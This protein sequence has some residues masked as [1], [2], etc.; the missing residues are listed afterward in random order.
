MKNS[1]LP[2]CHSLFSLK[3]PAKINW[4]L[5]IINKR[6]DGYHN[7][8]SFMQ[9]IDIYDTLLFESAD[10]VE[11]ISDLDISPESNL[12]YKAALLLKQYTTYKKGVKITLQKTIPV[13]A[14]LGGGS[15][16]AAYTLLGLNKLWRLGL[17]HEEICTIGLKIGSDVPFFIHS[18]PSIVEGRGEKI[19]NL[20][21]HNSSIVLL[22]VKPSVAVSTAR[23]YELF[24]R[25]RLPEL[26]KKPLDIKLFCH[27]LVKRDFISLST[28]LHNDLE[29]IVIEEYPVI[30][31]IKKRMLENGAIISSMTGSGPAVFGVFDSK[32]TAS[33]A[34]NTMGA[35]YWCS[36]TETMV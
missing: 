11:L 10:D 14:G 20:D 16:D 9:C 24:D 32:K 31:K 4:F 34:A 6:D 18:S 13:S 35:D 17:E 29:K 8:I 26:T 5:S 21:L 36:V 22:L 1:Y 30:E 23:A 15:S 33:S 27:A 19:T 7:I 3:A 28:M 2:T 25:N 12:V